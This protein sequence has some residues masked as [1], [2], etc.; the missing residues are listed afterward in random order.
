MTPRHIFR[1]LSASLAIL[2][3]LPAIGTAAAPAPDAKATKEAP[4]P[5]ALDKP[6]PE[7]VGD[8]KA[9]QEQ[10]KKVVA[11]VIPC[12][13]NIRDSGGQGSGVI[14]SEDGYVLTAGHVSRE[15]NRD[16]VVTLSDGRKLKAKT[17]G[18]NHYIDSGMVKITEAGKWPHVDLG[19]SADLKKGQWVITTG[20]PGGWKEGRG[21]VVRL[22]RV[23][24]NTSELI[25]TDC[26][27]VGGD[28]GGPL[29][30][31]TGKVVGI[32]SRIAFS[33]ASNIHVPVDTYRATWDRLVKGDVWGNAWVGFQPDNKTKAKG[34]RVEEV[35]K[36]SPAEKGGLKPDDLITKFNGQKI[37]SLDD[38]GSRMREVNIGAEVA[39]EVKRGEETLSLKVKVAKTDRPL[40]N[41]PMEITRDDVSK[42]S[43]KVLTAF[44][45]LENRA[46]QSTVKVEC[47]GKDVVL[48]TVVGPDG[49]V[50]TKFSE[51]KGNKMTCKL[52]DGR[53][54]EARVVGIEE[55]FDLALLKVD[56]KGL[57][58]VEWHAS[59][60]AP[61]GSLG[62]FDRSGPGPARGRRRQRRCPQGE[63]QGC[64]P[65]Q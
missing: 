2:L 24:Q 6:A 41:G 27:I 61:V 32:H 52:A 12:T 59:K 10:I 51:L 17:V 18:A 7:N 60:E 36:D 54:L 57:T 8:L 1:S 31:M 55:T 45:D 19:K 42:N 16:V 48:G 33:L 58:P 28:S 47:D 34:C 23:L 53:D 50:L 35:R 43:N 25:R 22:G 62:R 11:K 49:W 14:V 46:R 20:H 38:F 15:A 5:A 39:L 44:R 63:P 30:D 3:V 65:P 4:L 40:P 37:E 21:V 9:I 13:V 26:T 56:T 29:F 64:A